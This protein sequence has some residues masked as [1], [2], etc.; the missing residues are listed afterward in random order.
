MD[1]VLMENVHVIKIGLLMIALKEDVL[2]IV[3][4]MGYVIQVHIH[5]FVKMVSVVL[6][7]ISSNVLKIAEVKIKESV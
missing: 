5:V 4:V 7:A 2:M 6:I 1:Y 3:A